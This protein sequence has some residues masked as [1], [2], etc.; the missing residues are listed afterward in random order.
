MVVK[1]IDYNNFAFSITFYLVLF[2]RKKTTYLVEHLESSFFMQKSWKQKQE[3]KKNLIVTLCVHSFME[4]IL[5]KFNKWKKPGQTFYV[6][7]L[8]LGK[9]GNYSA[10]AK[11]TDEED[12][13]FIETENI[14]QCNVGKKLAGSYLLL[15]NKCSTM[16]ASI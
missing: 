14:L 13:C 15:W 11:I 2:S 6:F 12:W 10:T 3:E 9:K 5:K 1:E 8:I 7:H 16:F 4:D